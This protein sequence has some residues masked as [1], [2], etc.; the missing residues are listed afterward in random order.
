MT[1][2][3]PKAVESGK[4][5]FLKNWNIY[6]KCCIQNTGQHA[7]SKLQAISCNILNKP[8]DNYTSHTWR[9]SA[10]TNL[11]D[12]GVSLIIL[13][14]HGQC[15]SDSV[16]EGYIANSQPLCQERLHCLLLEVEGEK[17]ERKEKVG[18]Q[19]NEFINNNNFVENNND[20]SSMVDLS[21]LR[22]ELTGTQQTDLTLYRFSQYYEPDVDIDVPLL[23]GRQKQKTADKEDLPSTATTFEKH[24]DEW[25]VRS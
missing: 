11:A 3:Y 9:K 19:L 10:V 22:E 1:Q 14:R 8:G 20:E 21:N 13:K 16:V 23:T 18:Q 25:S 6:G 2:I 5:Q 15:V 7:I 24:G 4:L 12:A 17:L